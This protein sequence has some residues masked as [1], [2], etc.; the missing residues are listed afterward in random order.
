MSE[1]PNSGIIFR[2]T[3]KKPGTKRPGWLLAVRA[4]VQRIDAC[5]IP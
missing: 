1:Y 5:C 4:Y 3:Y 2:N